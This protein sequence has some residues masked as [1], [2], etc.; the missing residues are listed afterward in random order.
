MPKR[1]LRVLCD[2]GLVNLDAC[3][4]DLI[5]DRW[6]LAA[7]ACGVTPRQPATHASGF[8]SVLPGPRRLG[9]GLFGRLLEGLTGQ[10]QETRV[11]H[12]VHEP[13]GT[14]HTR[15]RLTPEMKARLTPGHACCL[16]IDPET[17]TGT[18][19]LVNKPVDFTLPGLM[20][21]RQ[22][23]TQCASRPG[24]PRPSTGSNP[25]QGLRPG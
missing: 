12:K 8:A 2:E 25:Q 9:M 1:Q 13:L 7:G 20:L 17:R 21:A 15:I 22:V 3:L 19:V 6:P 14:L 5:G 18:V 16:S 10:G 23:C 4:G 24:P 11:A